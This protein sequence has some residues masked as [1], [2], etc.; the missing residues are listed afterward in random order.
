MPDQGLGR[1]GEQAH[2]VAGLLPT[3]SAHGAVPGQGL[4]AGLPMFAHVSRCLVMGIVNVTPNSFSDG[5]LYRTS[6][7]AVAHGRE[8]IRQGA[9]I[10][11]IGGESTKPGAARVSEAEELA[12]TLPVVSALAGYIATQQLP[13]ALSIDTMRASVAQAAVDAGASIINDVSGGL[14]DPLMPLVVASTQAVYIAMHWLGHSAQMDELERR[15]DI[16]DSAVVGEVYRHLEGRLEALT[17]AGI[18]ENRIVLDPGL[19]FSKA[20]TANWTLLRNLDQLHQLGRPLLI[21]AS[22]KRFLS[23]VSR[24]APAPGAGVQAGTSPAAGSFPQVGPSSPVGPVSQAGLPSP[25]SDRDGATAAVTALAAH[26]GAWAVRVHNVAA[27]RDAVHVAA[28]WMGI[29]A[30]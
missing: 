12:R 15:A 24:P 6:Q 30:S 9:D 22:R 1:A 16:H 26:G 23:P 8:L 17:A 29:M 11:D 25:A 28:A 5:G 27:N 3:A 19:G 4:L 18:P 21:G 20:G 2:P 14:A 7:A 13:V 10:V